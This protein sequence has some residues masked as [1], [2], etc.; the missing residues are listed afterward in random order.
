MHPWKERI[1]RSLVTLSF[2]FFPSFFLSFFSLFLSFFQMF[3]LTDNNENYKWVILQNSRSKFFILL[4]SPCIFITFYYNQHAQWYYNSIYHNSLICVIYTPTC[5]DT[6]VSSS[7]SLQ[8]KLC[9]VTYIIQISAV[10]KYLNF[11][12][13]VSTAA[14]RRMCTT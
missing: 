11:M 7:G 4:H 13:C 3:R 14:I 9:L 2:F 6:L 8:P 5:I 10:E 1:P 12:N